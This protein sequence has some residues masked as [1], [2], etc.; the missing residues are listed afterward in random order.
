[1]SY[2]TT[3]PEVFPY[4]LYAEEKLAAK[5]ITE[6]ITER[7]GVSNGSSFAVTSDAPWPT[8]RILWLSSVSFNSLPDEYKIE[9]HSTQIHY[10]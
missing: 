3:L 1:M 9:C 4:K 2:Q 6:L 10:E 8:V 5:L 7:E